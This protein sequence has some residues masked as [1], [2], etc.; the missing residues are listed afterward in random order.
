MATPIPLLIVATLALASTGT[1]DAPVTRRIP[2]PAAPC[3]DS[4]MHRALDFWLGDWEVQAQGRTIGESR[5]EGASDGCAVLETFRARDGFTGR[6]LNYVDPI[7]GRWHQ[8]W[9]DNQGRVSLFT[10]APRDGGLALEGETRGRDGTR[11]LRRMTLAPLP[12]GRVRQHSHRSTDAGRTWQTAYD[13]VYV[14]RRR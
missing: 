5:I 10:G 3:R 7:D 11:V 6:S 2:Q 9:A 13:Y 8:A 4:A 1:P 14:R 12:D